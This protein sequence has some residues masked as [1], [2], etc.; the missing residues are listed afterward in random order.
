MKISIIGS[1][2]VGCSAAVHILIRELCNKLVLIDVI[3]GLP[4]GEA[5]DLAHMCSI[6]GLSIDVLGSNDFKEI[7]NS[8]IIIITAGLT[9][10][11]GMTREE[12]LL[13]NA[14]II[15]DICLKI[16]Q[17]SPNSIVV[18]V[19]N[20][21]DIMTYLT[22]KVLEIDR[23]KV[24]GFSGILDSGRL[25]Y[26]ISKK[27]NVSPKS[28]EAFI[29]GQH[30]EKMIPLPNHCRVFGLPL[31]RLLNEIEI[32]EIINKTI[33][34]GEEIVKLKKWSAYHAVGVGIAI[35]VE[36]I[37]KDKKEVHGISA[38]LN[39]EYNE[40]DVVAEVP[41]IIGRNGIIKIIELD[42]NEEERKL[43]REAIEWIR[44]H[45]KIL[46]EKGIL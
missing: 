10:K 28:I 2:R 34:A 14:K 32:K 19:T 11:P 35:L 1:G 42:L 5:L 6:L 12:L 24:I 18:V 20:P 44:K 4:Q 38:V 26:Y 37:V 7:E 36:S 16:K 15:K 41:A 27:L 43:F 30:G 21:L 31:T 45:I 22:W 46:Y 40:Y 3:E 17:Y 8:D 9:R 39:G 13:E 23:S 33:K 29:I 25:K